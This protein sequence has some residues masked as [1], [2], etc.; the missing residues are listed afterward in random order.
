MSVPSGNHKFYAL[1]IQNFGIILH[2]SKK[3]NFLNSAWYEVVSPLS[4][5]IPLKYAVFEYNKTE[6][7][8]SL[9]GCA[10]SDKHYKKL[11]E[12]TT[13]ELLSSSAEQLDDEKWRQQQTDR[14]Q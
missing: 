13:E 4:L 10:K 12:F 9:I 7:I 14:R 8:F 11:K 3:V 1:D 2:L 5:V 6:K